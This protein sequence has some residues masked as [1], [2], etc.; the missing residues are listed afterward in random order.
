M[1][2]GVVLY[3]FVSG[4]VAR[5]SIRE[6]QNN[7]AQWSDRPDLQAST[8]RVFRQFMAF[9]DSLL[10]KLDVWHGRI[11]LEHLDVDD[12]YGGS[13]VGASTSRAWTDAGGCAL[14]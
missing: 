1:L 10:D 7:L 6:Y 5:N 14:R 12:P 13:P 11:G 3:F 9:A 8:M 2:Y 4:R